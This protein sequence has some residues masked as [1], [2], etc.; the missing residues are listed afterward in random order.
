MLGESSRL[1]HDR[2]GTLG[3]GRGKLPSRHVGAHC[4]VAME[5]PADRTAEARAIVERLPL[6][7]TGRLVSAPSSS[8]VRS[9]S[10]RSRTRPLSARALT[11]DAV[12]LERLQRARAPLPGRQAISGVVD[13]VVAS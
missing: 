7:L 6:P 4:T 11:G 3:S 13:H 5:F 1:L 2:F 8:S 9:A 10:S 12:G